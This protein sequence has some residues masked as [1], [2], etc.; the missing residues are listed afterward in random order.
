MSKLVGKLKHAASFCSTRSS[1]SR[2]SAD[3][4]I[5]VPSPATG[6]PSGS[7]SAENIL[8]EEKHLKFW[9]KMEKD[10]YKQLKTHRFILS[11]AYDPALGCR[12]FALEGTCSRAMDHK[13]HTEIHAQ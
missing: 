6:V 8:L 3:M 11:P 13:I 4:Q 1:S 10:I 5:D 2:G 7:S 9:D 12:N